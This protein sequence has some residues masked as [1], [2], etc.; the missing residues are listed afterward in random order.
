MSGVSGTEEVDVPLEVV[1]PVET[2]LRSLNPMT[3]LNLCY[4]T[5]RPKR[6]LMIISWAYSKL[7]GLFQMAYHYHNRKARPI[8]IV[9]TEAER[10][11]FWQMTNTAE[12]QGPK[13]ECWE[14]GGAHYNEGYGRITIRRINIRA[15]RLAYMLYYRTNP[16]NQMVLH[17]CDNPPCVRPSHLSL[18]DARKNRE[19]CKQRGRVGKGLNAGP[20]TRS[21]FTP[22]RIKA[23]R[24]AW[25]LGCI[26]QHQLALIAGTKQKTM[27][28]I[29][30]RKS[31]DYP[32]C[33]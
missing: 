4:N 26:S 18:G 27:N 12:G 15:H 11:K 8:P 20:A 31:W 33:G 13:G 22:E 30:N 19:H 32:E 23:I 21:V 7:K 29:L 16:G 17:E 28:D 24:A 10:T 14:W 25:R 6:Q 9:L 5:D 1:V 2:C 3:H